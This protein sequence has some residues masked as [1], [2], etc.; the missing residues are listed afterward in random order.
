MEGI[1]YQAT[2]VVN[3]KMYIG[4]TI[5]TLKK[6]KQ[7]HEADAR[8]GSDYIFHKAL[9]KYGVEN[10]KWKIL[11][12]TSEEQLNEL[13]KFYIEKYKTHY[14]LN[15][16][17][18]MTYGGEGGLIGKQNGMYGKGLFG[19][20]NGMYG[21]PHPNKGKKMPITS[22]KIS[23]KN[24]GKALKIICHVPDNRVFLC[25]GNIKKFANYFN[26]SPYYLGLLYSNKKDSINGF[27]ARI[28]GESE[29]LPESIIIFEDF[30]KEL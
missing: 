4:K 8:R 15:S 25:H 18:N 12:K 21:K 6:R 3:N 30:L 17:Y 10:F 9:R 29:I 19:N 16:G 27:T 26:I 24:N 1:I 5:K 7:L 23:G 13:E 28:L 2:N 14:S 11:C 22:K 20:K